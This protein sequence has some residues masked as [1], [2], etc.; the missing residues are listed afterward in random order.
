M[1]DNTTGRPGDHNDQDDTSRYPA[2]QQWQQPSSNEPA[3]ANQ[4]YGQPS[5]YGQ[6]QGASPYGGQGGYGGGYGQPAENPGKTLGIVGMICSIIWPISI[7][8]LIVSIIAMVKSKKAGMGNGFALAGIII[9]AIGVVTGIL[10]I[11]LIIVGI[12]AAA[13]ICNELGSGTHIYQGTEITCP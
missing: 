13:E 9:G 3:P 10:T 5:G 11:I 12:S 2:G 6:P 1:S 7:V 4:S 8:G